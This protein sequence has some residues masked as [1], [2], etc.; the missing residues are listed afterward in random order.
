MKSN[1]RKIS[2]FL[3]FIFFISTILSLFSTV[4]AQYYNPIQNKLTVLVNYPSAGYVTP[5]TGLYYYGFT[6]TAR[7]YTNLGYSFDGWYLNGIY[8]GKLSTIKITMYQDY[9]LYAVFSMNPTGGEPKVAAPVFS[10]LVGTYASVQSVA[11]SCSTAGATIRYT[12]DNTNPTSTTGTIYYGAISVGSSA[13]IKA[14]AYKSG[15]IDSDVANA[16]YA[17][18]TYAIT[19]TQ[20]ANGVIAPAT[21][22]VNYGGSQVFTVTPSAGYF[23]ASLT[24]DGSAVTV[25]ASYT[26][27]NV[28]A[29]HTI[30]ATYALS[31]STAHENIIVQAMSFDSTRK[32]VTMYVQSTGGLTPVVNSIII[33]DASGSTI[34]TVGIASI[35]P[36]ATG[37]A[38]AKD[39]LYS[40]QGVALTNVLGSGTFTATLTTAADGSYISPTSTISNPNVTSTRTP[41]SFWS[42]NLLALVSVSFVGV[43]GVVVSAVSLKRVKTSKRNL[44]VKLVAKGEDLVKKN[45]LFGA[46]ECFA[47]ASIVGFKTKSIDWATKA[48]ERYIAIA[49]S[50]VINSVL[51]GAKTEAFKRIS[52]LQSEIAKN[53]S[54][55]NMQ[56]LIGR[57]S[58]EG[59]RGL[60]LLISKAGDN[61]LDFVVD[62]A[63]RLPEVEHAF[64]GALGGLDEV[65]VVDLAAKLGYS[66]DATFRLLSKSINLKKVEGYITCDGKKFVSKEYVQKQLSAHL[67]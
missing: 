37:N 36:I 46:V 19:V 29:T 59:V 38:L 32:I 67:K 13:T 64:L 24:V 54:D 6:E 50:L 41:T 17:I 33:K 7:V 16:T 12:T 51:S 60:D 22:S 43:V 35:S 28:V 8:Q 10:P 40:I 48:L 57:S 25:A 66:V 18:N 1:V 2:V 61:Y 21:T 9:T 31:T 30:T 55:K 26:F 5:G 52:K 11:L 42:E 3:L 34:A 14:I 27:T 47:K 49:K 62:D 58:L 53:I 63:L 65:L 23:I 44:C 39:N 20:G 15:M 4:S 45:D 56:S